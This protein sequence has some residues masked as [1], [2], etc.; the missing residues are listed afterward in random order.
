MDVVNTNSTL[1]MSTSCP[2]ASVTILVPA[3]LSANSRKSNVN[4]T[5]FSQLCRVFRALAVY[6]S[7]NSSD[8]RSARLGSICDE[9]D[10]DEAVSDV[11][12]KFYRYGQDKGFESLTAIKPLILIIARRHCNDLFRA[13]CSEAE[14]VDIDSLPDLAD[15]TVDMHH[16]ELIELIKDLGEP[17]SRLIWLR[18]FYGLKSKEIAKETGLKPNTVDKRIARALSKLKAKLEEEM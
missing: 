2:H 18:Y 9:R 13:K 16:A 8:Q 17:D 1:P 10:I 5:P 14:A 3:T 6:P 4:T 12:V 11:F 15:N 7:F